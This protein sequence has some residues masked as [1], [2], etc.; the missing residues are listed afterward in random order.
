MLR[1]TSQ[2]TKQNQRS[3]KR[4]TT[5]QV[6]LKI[7][8]DKMQIYHFPDKILFWLGKKLIQFHGILKASASKTCFPAR[9]T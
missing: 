1:V 3:W 4:H 6:G 5:I 9:A 7:K 2:I 8:V